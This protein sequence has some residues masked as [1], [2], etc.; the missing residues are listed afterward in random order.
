MKKVTEYICIQCPMGCP[1][2]LTHE[3]KEIIEI[4]GYTC[5][6]GAKYARQEFTDPR[7]SL[8]TTISIEGALWGRLP[9]KV[10]QPLPK[11]RVIEAAKVIHSLKV[12]SPVKRGQ[13]LI[14][15]ILGDEGSDVVACRSM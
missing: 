6:R 14:K 2:Q 4:E 15:N 3:A 11:N 1:L 12:K 8:S 13:V 5:N 10:T 7:R 9:V